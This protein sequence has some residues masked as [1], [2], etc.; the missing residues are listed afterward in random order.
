MERD[1]R[2]QLGPPGRRLQCAGDTAPIAAPG[3]AGEPCQTGRCAH[4]EAGEWPEE[5]VQ[6]VVRWRDRCAAHQLHDRPR[7][8]MSWLA[9][10]TAGGGLIML[11]LH[12]VV[13]GYDKDDRP[14]LATVAET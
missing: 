5:A 4:A 8:E 2:G 9:R 13:A 12:D 3:Q 7:R 10:A 14:R 1:A 6:H 11:Q